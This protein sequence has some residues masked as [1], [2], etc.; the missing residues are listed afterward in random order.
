[1]IWRSL[2]VDGKVIGNHNEYPILNTFIYD[3]EL[4]YGIINSYAANVIA[5]NILSQVDSEGSHSQW[6]ESISRYSKDESA[7]EKGEQW[8]TTKRVNRVRRKTKIGWKFLVNLKHGLQEWVPLK[9]L[10]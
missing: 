8:M 5:Q 7:V 3:V 9:L 2:D 4:Q 6:L 10:K 1:M